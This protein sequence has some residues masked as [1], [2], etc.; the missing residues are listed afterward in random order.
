MLGAGGLPLAG[1]SSGVPDRR[2]P[3]LRAGPGL[4]DAEKRRFRG[5]TAL[6]ERVGT[7][8]PTP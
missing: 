8:I 1:M 5:L 3:A 2:S 6:A 7:P 4:R